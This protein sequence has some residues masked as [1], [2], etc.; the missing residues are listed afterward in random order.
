LIDV[1]EPEVQ[2]YFCSLLAGS[3]ID[4]IGAEQSITALNPEKFGKV[5]N[6][7][8]DLLMEAINYLDRNVRADLASRVIELYRFESVPEESRE[9]AACR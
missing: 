1:L 7:N 6:A 5:L 2:L 9:P 4:I 8:K 3:T